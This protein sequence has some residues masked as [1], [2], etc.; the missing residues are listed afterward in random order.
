M[1]SNLCL[2]FS[3]TVPLRNCS[4]VRTIPYFKRQNHCT[5]VPN[6]W[7]ICDSYCT[8]GFRVWIEYVLI[9][10]SF[11]IHLW[12]KRNK[13]SIN[14]KV[15]FWAGVLI[16]C[17]II[18]GITQSF[19]WCDDVTQ[20]FVLI[21]RK[22]KHYRC[23]ITKIEAFAFILKYI[24]YIPYVY[25]LRSWTFIQDFFKNLQSN[26]NTLTTWIIAN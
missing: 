26:E 2:S 7:N 1:Y 25:T 15:E 8:S 5:S 11:D 17:F 10:F 4:R 21:K 20:Y 6:T 9:I 3:E 22:K 13:L 23:F 19:H 14:I 16:M 18:P 12:K 24:K